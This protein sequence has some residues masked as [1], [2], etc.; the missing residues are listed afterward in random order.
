[1][2]K[3]NAAAIVECFLSDVWQGPQD[4]DAVDLSVAP[5]FVITTG[6]VDVVS[7]ERFKAWVID[8][9]SRIS[10]GDCWEVAKLDDAQVT[11]G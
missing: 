8:F 1:M 5:D 4:V 11:G 6:G 2:E 3:I 10:P 7:R 9:W